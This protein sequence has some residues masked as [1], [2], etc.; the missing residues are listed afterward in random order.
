MRAIAEGE[1]HN[2]EGQKGA[3]KMREE[4]RGGEW[5]QG[6]CEAETGRYHW[7]TLASVRA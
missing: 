1:T 7:L 5:R 2:R 6:E 4:R 3:D